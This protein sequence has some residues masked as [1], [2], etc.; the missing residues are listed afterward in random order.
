[1][2]RNSVRRDTG[3]QDLVLAIGLVWGHVK[4][5]QVEQANQLARGCL[6]VWPYS[7]QLQVMAAYA[8]VEMGGH[9]DGSTRRMLEDADCDEWANVILQRHE[10]SKQFQ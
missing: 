9:L 8:S 10:R 4:C 1:M 7:V 5:G 3:D 2:N 6:R